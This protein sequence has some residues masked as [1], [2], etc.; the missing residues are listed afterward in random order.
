LTESASAIEVAMISEWI[1]SETDRFGVPKRGG[2]W[3]KALQRLKLHGI[4]MDEMRNAKAVPWFLGPRVFSGGGP[5]EQIFE[6][7]VG[8]SWAIV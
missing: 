5:W 1:K 4:R 6:I 2:G 7:F 3:R 8:L